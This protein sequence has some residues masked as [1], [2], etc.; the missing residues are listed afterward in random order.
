MKI[1]EETVMDFQE[2]RRYVGSEFQHFGVKE[3]MLL[4]GKE[5]GVRMMQVKNGGKL[6]FD[7]VADR[8][9]DIGNLEYKGLE[10]RND[11]YGRSL[12]RRREKIGAARP[13]ALYTR[14]RGQRANGKDGY[15]CAL[16]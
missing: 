5:N 7:V 9:L 2:L 13:A 12:R 16:Y 10:L 1:E 3:F 8:A 4:R 6:R 11:A 14:G 15:Q